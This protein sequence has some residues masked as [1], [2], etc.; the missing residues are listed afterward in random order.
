LE[1][2]F[3][4]GIVQPRSFVPSKVEPPKALLMSILVKSKTQPK[5][6]HDIKCF[7]CQGHGN[8]ASECPN[9][10]I[11]MIRDNGDIESKS[12]RSN[13]EGMPP[14]E[15]ND[16]RT[17]QVQIKEDETNQQRENIFHTRFYV[18]NKV[19]SLNIDSGSC[20]NVFSTTLVNKLILCIVKYVKPYRLQ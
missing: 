6:I 20:V 1:V 9:K 4:K 18:Q 14:L 19:C 7:R 15:D 8:Y 12:N 3:K 16:G 13:Y 11:M 10:R 2:E 17:L 5:R